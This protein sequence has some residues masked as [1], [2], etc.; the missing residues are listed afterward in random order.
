MIRHAGITLLTD[1]AGTPVQVNIDLLR[2]G[3][4]IAPF[5][6]AHGLVAAT[7]GGLSDP[8][9]SGAVCDELAGTLGGGHLTRGYLPSPGQKLTPVVYHPQVRLLLR[10]AAGRVL[11]SLRHRS[12]MAAP[13]AGKYLALLLAALEKRLHGARRRHKPAPEGYERYGPDMF[14]LRFRLRSSPGFL[15]VVCYTL[16]HATV[17]VRYVG[18]ETKPDSTRR[19]E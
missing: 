8:E 17:L 11:D 1:E 18:T 13:P 9:G 2:H 19:R 6:R 12:G 14:G 7:S 16:H 10:E 4:E 5:L 15:W 3:A